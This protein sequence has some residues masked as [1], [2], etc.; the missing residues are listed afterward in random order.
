MGI[1]G[2]CRSRQAGLLKV[3]HVFNDWTTLPK[4]QAQEGSPAVQ[5]LARPG[6]EEHQSGVRCAPA[7]TCLFKPIVEIA[8]WFCVVFV[9]FCVWCCVWFCVVGDMHR[10]TCT[11]TY[12]HACTDTYMHMHAHVLAAIL[13]QVLAAPDD[14]CRS[15]SSFSPCS[16]ADPLRVPKDPEGPCWVSSDHRN[17]RLLR[18]PLHP[19]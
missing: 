7:Q 6:Q 19:S 18:G 17:G 2:T 3:V 8:Y 14:P 16:H 4:V 11:C 5:V 12:T 1:H 15:C 9:W 13:P 10:L